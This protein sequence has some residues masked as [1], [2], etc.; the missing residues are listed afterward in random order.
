MVFVFTSYV[1]FYKLSESKCV[2]I[3]KLNIYEKHIEKLE[4]SV[5]YTITNP[6]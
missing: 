4:N 6:E 2:F 3:Q 5:I 1:L